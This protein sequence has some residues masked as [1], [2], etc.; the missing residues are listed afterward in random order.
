VDDINMFSQMTTVSQAGSDPNSKDQDGKTPLTHAKENQ[1][2]EVV[3]YLECLPERDS[4]TKSTV[5]IW[6]DG[7][8]TLVW[9][10]AICIDQNNE[11]ERTDQ[12]N[13][14]DLV[15]RYSWYSLVWLGRK[16]D[17]TDLAFQAVSKLATAKGDITRSKIV[18][19]TA[20]D[21]SIY[22]QPGTP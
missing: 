9:I 3:L 5:S 2:S 19:Y 10:D 18:P 7:P 16:E 6:S 21:P 22:Q 20:Q 13:H 4:C 17:Y 14:M 12:V 15:F 11:T 1:H 8:E